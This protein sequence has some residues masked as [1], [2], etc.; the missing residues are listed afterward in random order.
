[1]A[2]PT[3]NAGAVF[4]FTALI[5]HARASNTAERNMWFNAFGLNSGGDI[6]RGIEEDANHCVDTA[7]TIVKILEARGYL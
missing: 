7:E 1:M 3:D 5:V 2:A 6:E 4:L